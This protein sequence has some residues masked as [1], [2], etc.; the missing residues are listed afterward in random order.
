[1]LRRGG[2]NGAKEM[3]RHV[4]HKMKRVYSTFYGKDL[5]NS[6]AGYILIPSV[7]CT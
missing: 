4:K 2:R 1:M 5:C 7:F 6:N 3:T